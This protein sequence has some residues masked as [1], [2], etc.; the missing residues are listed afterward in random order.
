MRPKGSLALFDG[1]V[2]GCWVQLE[3]VYKERSGP[4][5]KNSHTSNSLTRFF[6]EHPSHS[7]SSAH[8]TCPSVGIVTVVLV[9]ESLFGSSQQELQLWGTLLLRCFL[10]SAHISTPRCWHTH[11]HNFC[12]SFLFKV[13][14]GGLSMCYNVQQR[15]WNVTKAGE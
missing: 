4:F 7:V 15:E 14:S 12:R 13:L 11:S 5:W 2:E 10:I 9:I 8:N 6:Q 3:L 1:L